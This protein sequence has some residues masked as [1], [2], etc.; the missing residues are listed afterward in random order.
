MA[1]LR[2]G[3][4]VKSTGGQVGILVM[5]LDAV[6]WEFHVADQVT[7]LTTTIRTI[8]SHEVAQATFM[9]IP[10]GRRPALDVARRLGY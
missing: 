1:N 7:G 8:L 10:E 9:D 6:T 2:K 4:W 5:P 3:M